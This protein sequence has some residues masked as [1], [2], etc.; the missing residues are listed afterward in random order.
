MIEDNNGWVVVDIPRTPQALSIDFIEKE[1]LKHPQVD[2]PVY[3]RFGPG[4]YIREV[5]LPKG[6]MAIG[7]RQKTEHMNVMISGKVIMFNQDGTSKTISGPITFAGKPGRK[8]GFILEDTIWQNIYA[9]DERSVEKLEKLYL[10]KSEYWKGANDIY[11][12]IDFSNRD[13]DRKDF[14]SMVSEIGVLAETIR[15]QS[16]NTEDQVDMPYGWD[17]TAVFDSSIE[18]KGLFAT[19]SFSLNE[20]IAPARIDGKRTPAGRY[21]NHSAQPNAKMVLKENGD[22]DLVAIRNIRG[23]QGGDFGEEIIIDY[24]QSFSLSF[25]QTGKGEKLCLE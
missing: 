16:E 12:D 10:D 22:I 14:L 15:E 13:I 4:I 6:A 25:N 24:R 11:K 5:H 9:T 20:T 1:M 7:H 17:K 2:C 19:S 23:C 8:I 18:G 3:H 21:T